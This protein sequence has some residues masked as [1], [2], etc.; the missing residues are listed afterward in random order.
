MYQVYSP[1]T[2]LKSRLRYRSN[3]RTPV[4]AAVTKLSHLNVA[5]IALEHDGRTR[6]VTT[7][8]MLTSV[9]SSFAGASSAESCSSP[10]ST[11]SA[12]AFLASKGR[13]Q[14]AS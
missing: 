14:R 11:R 13:V 3:D 9:L 8:K 1:T 7:R 5:K 6:K 12:L 4:G 10:S 2:D